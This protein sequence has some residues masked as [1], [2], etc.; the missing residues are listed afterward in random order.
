MGGGLELNRQHSQRSADQIRLILAT[1]LR[2][3]LRDPR[4]GFVTLTG[5]ELSSDK[6]VA[7]VFVSFIGDKVD[8]S[9]RALRKAAPFLRRALAK[10]A[11]WRFTPELRFEIDESIEGGF[12]VDRILEELEETRSPA[13]DDADSAPSEETR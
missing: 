11:N 13:E 12:R 3:E 4:I 9:F 5:V 10:R 7:R 2:E 1:V 8:E 6:R